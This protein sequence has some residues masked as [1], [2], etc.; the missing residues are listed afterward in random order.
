MA[1]DDVDLGSAGMVVLPDQPGAFPH[2][3]VTNGK[4]GISTC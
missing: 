4:M 3:L 1:R 2:L